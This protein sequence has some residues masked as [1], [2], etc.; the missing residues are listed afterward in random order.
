MVEPAP[1]VAGLEGLCLAKDATTL[2]VAGPASASLTWKR[3]FLFSSQ[4]TAIVSDGTRAV[5]R[6]RSFPPGNWSS[7]RQVQPRRFENTMFLLNSAARVWRAMEEFH[8]RMAEAMV[9][10]GARVVIVLAAE[11]PAEIRARL[12]SSGAVVQALPYRNRWKFYRGLRRLIADYRIARVHIRFFRAE[13]LV[14]WVVRACG[15]RHICYTEANVG[16]SH[17]RG[18]RR[19]A[20]NVRLRLTTWPLTRMI[21]ISEFVRERLVE[22]G[23]PASKAVVVYNG[24]DLGRFTP[25]GA[26]KETYRARFGA[27]N[28]ELVLSTIARLTPV[29]RIDLILRT[30]RLL[31]ERGLRFRLIIAGQ[32]GSL[33]EP[34]RQLSHELGLDAHVVWLGETGEPET[35]LRATDVFVFTSA[36]EAFGNVLVE[37]MACG[38][39]IV[40]SRRGAIPEIVEDQLCGLLPSADDPDAYAKAIQ[41]LAGDEHRR[42]QLAEGAVRRASRFSVERAVQ[43]TLDVYGP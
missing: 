3:D 26:A 13:Q 21:A 16:E 40:G 38:V 10:G 19:T 33:A 42:R 14:A 25:P 11:P 36:A 20:R 12:E 29:K 1:D 31:H 15:V 37:A 24:I 23:I 4:G 27:G 43:N 41:E 34:L 17:A 9:Q 28:G 32:H 18:L 6:A 39:P 8:F 22:F 30:C 35:L 5:V 2:V 7:I